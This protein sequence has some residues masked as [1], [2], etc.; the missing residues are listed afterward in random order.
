MI[1][2]YCFFLGEFYMLPVYCNNQIVHISTIHTHEDFEN[3]IQ[4]L[5]AMKLNNMDDISSFLKQFYLIPATAYDDLDHYVSQILDGSYTNEAG[6]PLHKNKHYKRI[7]STI[8]NIVSLKFYKDQEQILIT[9]LPIEVF[10]LL[11]SKISESDIKKL[12]FTAIKND[13]YR[14]NVRDFFFGIFMGNIID[15]QG[16]QFSHTNYEEIYNLSWIIVYHMILEYSKSVY[17]SRK[18]DFPP[19]AIIDLDD[20][21]GSVITSISK[22]ADRNRN[23]LKQKVDAIKKN[24]QGAYSYIRVCVDHEITRRLNSMTKLEANNSTGDSEPILPEHLVEHAHQ[25]LQ[26]I[27]YHALLLPSLQ[28]SKEKRIEQWLTDLEN[29]SVSEEFLTQLFT[30]SNQTV[31][32]QRIHLLYLSYQTNNPELLENIQDQAQRARRKYINKL[33]QKLLQELS[34]LEEQFKSVELKKIIQRIIP[35]IFDATT[36]QERVKEATA[37]KNILTPIVC[38]EILLPDLLEKILIQNIS[39]EQFLLEC[40]ALQTFIILV[41]VVYVLQ[42][43]THASKEQDPPKDS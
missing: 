1:T 43:R 4:H 7:A 3:I 26:G 10:L 42:Q 37:L 27:S 12:F 21:Q 2:K 9:K 28:V 16:V 13:S 6:S 34:L 20:V 35:K 18:K 31:L 19:E 24:S 36:D 15:Q 30:R 17:N 29:M 32:I 23:H 38:G 40:Q 14:S 22:T 11:H 39:T 41:I 5:F 33:L 25:K 8:Q